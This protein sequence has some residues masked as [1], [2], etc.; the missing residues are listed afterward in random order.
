MGGEHD[1]TVLVLTS[2]RT[3]ENGK[4][5]LHDGHVPRNNAMASVYPWP[6][7]TVLKREGRYDVT[8]L[9]NI[10]A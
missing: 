5:T 2:A 9:V 4:A 7:V 10:H 8:M 6:G 1:Y 3:W